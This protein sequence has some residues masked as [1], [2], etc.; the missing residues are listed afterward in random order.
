MDDNERKFIFWLVRSVG[1][2][3]EFFLSVGWLELPEL[4]KP[5]GSS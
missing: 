2:S 1:K 4:L 3:I 5:V